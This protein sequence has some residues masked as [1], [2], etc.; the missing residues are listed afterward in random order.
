MLLAFLR[1]V[2]GSCRIVCHLVENIPFCCDIIQTQQMSSAK[3]N[4]EVTG[5]KNVFVVK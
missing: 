2:Q 4:I 3:T 1:P 5:M